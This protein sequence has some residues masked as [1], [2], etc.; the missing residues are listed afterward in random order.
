MPLCSSVSCVVKSCR[1]K[2]LQTH[3]LRATMT[4]HHFCVARAA[5]L[6][7]AEWYNVFTERE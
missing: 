7:A 2:K 4:L 5:N 3:G 1:P 6:A